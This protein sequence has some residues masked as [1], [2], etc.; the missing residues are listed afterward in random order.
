V[1]IDGPNKGKNQEGNDIFGFS[2]IME[3]DLYGNNPQN[4]L[5]PDANPLLWT[6]SL[7]FSYVTAWVVENGNL[8]YLKCPDELNW[9]TNTSCN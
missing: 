3:S 4:T 7:N 1:D 6:G 2:I 9:E 5:I 8:D